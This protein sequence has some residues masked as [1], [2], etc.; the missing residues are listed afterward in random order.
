[1]NEEQNEEGPVAYTRYDIVQID[2]DHVQVHFETNDDGDTGYPGD[3]AQDIL[4]YTGPQAMELALKH[5]GRTRQGI[6]HRV[7]VTVNGED[8]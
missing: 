7:T 5:C 8:W 2:N 1:M 4:E 3:F 6:G